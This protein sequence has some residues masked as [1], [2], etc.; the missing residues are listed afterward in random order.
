[1][2]ASR[3]L[4][5][6]HACGDIV[7][8]VDDDAYADPEWAGQILE[9][10]S[11][12]KIGGVGGQALNNV[13]GERTRVGPVG[14]LTPWGDVVGNF[15][16][17]IER[18]VNVDHLI[19]CNMSF[20]RD[21]LQELGG[22]SEFYPNGRCSTFEEL[23]LCMRL[24]NLGY[25]IVYTSKASVFHEGAPRRIGARGDINYIFGATRNLLTI[26]VRNRGV[27]SPIVARFIALSFWRS[28]SLFAFDCLRAILRFGAAACGIG[29]AL[30]SS[31]KQRAR[32]GKSLPLGEAQEIGMEGKAE[33]RA[34][35]VTEKA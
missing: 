17:D 24:A 25:L 34:C 13:A 7:A 4:G 15:G 27:F 23:D 32:R 10:Y 19:G 11:D 29:A 28:L 3:N 26:L 16:T 9:A 2:T 12:E 1:M 31:R 8:Y 22:F 14:R 6:E 35:G 30:L 20:R 18:T 21:L 5:L 33:P